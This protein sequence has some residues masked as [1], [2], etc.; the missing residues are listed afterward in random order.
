[1]RSGASEV[2]AKGRDTMGVIF[3]KPAQG[4][5]ITGVARN[6]DREIA[7]EVDA[8]AVA[9]IDQQLDETMDVAEVVDA[10]EAGLEEGESLTPVPADGDPSADEVALD[11]NHNGGNA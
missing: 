9:E 7:E 8:E 11:A 5:A 2:P 6:A 10:E 1:V 4:D 3:A